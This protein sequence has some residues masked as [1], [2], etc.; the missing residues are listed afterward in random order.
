[1][2]NAIE[3]T[4]SLIQRE[5]TNRKL[6]R[7][8][9]YFICLMVAA[10]VIIG[11]ATRLTDS[12]LSITEWKPLLGIFPPLS[13]AQWLSEF[14]KYRQIPE[15]QQ[16][17]KGMSLG[18][19]QF[20]YWWEWGHRFFGRMIGF[21]FAIPL[22]YFWISKRLEPGLKPRLLLLL[23]LGG[24]QGFVGW[25][26]VSSGLVERTD[27]SQYRLAT[28]LIIAFL[29]FA[30]ALWVA[31][32]LAPHSKEPARKIIHIMAPLMVMFI[33]F[34]IFLG[35]LVAG[36]DA[37]L[38]FNDW[39]LMDG[40]II[41]DSLFVIEPAW[42]NFFEN[43]KMVQFTHRMTAYALL[44]FIIFNLII[45]LNPSTGATHKRRA[46]IITIIALIQAAIGIITLLLQVPL[47]W[48]LLHQLGA[49]ILLGF[50]VAH[51]R[52]LSGGYPPITAIENRQ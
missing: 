25:W 8:W 31:R 1:M 9:L 29:I 15:Y 21:V 2:P 11:G 16:I 17:N 39:P 37:G 36:L 19:F 22:A 3:N 43:I 50:A 14:E 13:H 48:A 6:V 12:G 41:P 4:Q 24:L 40:A 20:I 51:W 52:A 32:G 38:A 42:L 47:S 23:A 49:L 28:H 46:V 27:V 10:I 45:S 5:L 30:Y 44:A 35:A 26:M 33:F 7:Y 18:E 34:Q